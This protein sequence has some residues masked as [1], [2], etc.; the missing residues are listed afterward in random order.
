MENQ[1]NAYLISKAIRKFLVA[2]ILT[3]AIIQV[4][5]TVDGII[6]SHLIGPD[7]MAAINLYT[8]VSLLIMS[9]CTFLGIGATILAARYMGEHNQEKTDAVLSTAIV[10]VV[11]VGVLMAVLVGLFRESLIDFICLEDRLR[12]YFHRYALVMLGC[13]GVVML[14]MLFNKIAS[15]DG[16]PDLVAKGVTVSAVTNMV[17]DYVFIAWF[18]MG[19]AG[20]AWASVIAVTANIALLARQQMAEHRSI[21]LNPFKGCSVLALKENM[22]QGTPMV[23]ANL[24]LMFNFF[25]LNMIVQRRQGADGVFVLSI[26]MNL[27]SIGMMFGSGIG[28]AVFAIGSFLDGQRDFQGLRILVHKCIGLFLVCLFAVVLLAQVYPQA[29]SVL[30]GAD[31]PEI[32]AYANS[33]LRIFSWMLPL[34]LLV[35]LLANVYQ[36]LGFLALPPILILA[37]PVVLL[38]SLWMWAEFVGND[39]LWYAFPQTGLVVFLINLLVTEVIRLKKKDRAHFTLVPIKKADNS[40]DISVQANISALNTSLD[41]LYAY[42]TDLHIDEKLS[43]RINV[44]LEEVM[45]NIVTHAERDQE[46]HYFDVHICIQEGVLTASVKDDGRA[47]NPLHVERDK[48][49]IGLKILFGYCKDLSYKYMYGQNMTFMNWKID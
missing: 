33:C 6:V 48:Q 11:S 49:G 18:D 24:I 19:I 17:L 9:V 32:A 29:I 13:S 20:S 15:T 45:L 21:L 30:F 25:M 8:P 23:M 44:C 5:V 27:L 47:F 31:T 4:N 37:F 14:N 34:L 1:R 26:C 42:L 22:K 10:S 43:K 35:I 39:Y 40:L 3:M 12:P 28:S 38:P 7:A 16:K 36:M 2:S 41:D 46:K